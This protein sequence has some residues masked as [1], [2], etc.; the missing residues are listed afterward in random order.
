M[1]EDI[2][3][4]KFEDFVYRVDNNQSAVDV[5]NLLRKRQ[6]LNLKAIGRIWDVHEASVS[7][8]FAGLQP[9]T[10]ENYIKGLRYFGY[11]L[12]AKP[13]EYN[14]DTG[15]PE[16]YNEEDYQELDNINFDIET[17]SLKYK[18]K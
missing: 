15:E 18:E 3:I 16:D 5:V 7:R 10:L 1:S 2:D 8:I 12:Y 14:T 11:T 6:K 13:I 4:M 17:N 9:I